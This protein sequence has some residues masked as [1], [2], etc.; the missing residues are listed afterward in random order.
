MVT[1][2]FPDIRVVS[3]TTE[4]EGDTMGEPSINISGCGFYE[5]IGMLV[6][7]LVQMVWLGEASLDD[8][9]YPTEWD[10]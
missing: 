3:V 7:G 10:E 6:Y 2:E 4:V 5:A 1:P 8:D 9:E